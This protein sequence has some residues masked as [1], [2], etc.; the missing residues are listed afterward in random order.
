MFLSIIPAT[1]LQITKEGAG[2]LAPHGRKVDVHYTGTLT[3]GSVFDS[4]RRRGRPF[5]FVLGAGQV[6]KGWDLGV[7]T[8]KAGEQARFTIDHALAYGAGGYPPVIPPRAVRP[9]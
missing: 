9:S 8:M 3:D 7:A 1:L 6:I 2:A 5:S 4:S